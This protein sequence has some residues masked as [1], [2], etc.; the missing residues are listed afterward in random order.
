MEYVIIVSEQM[1]FKKGMILMEKQGKICTKCGEWKPLEEY[2]KNKNCK[3]G[4]LSTC[5][6]CKKEQNKQW[7]KNNKEYWVYLF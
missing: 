3:D 6:E 5:R 4:R 2:H 7:N 1:I